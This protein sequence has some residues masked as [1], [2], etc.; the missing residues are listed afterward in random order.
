MTLDS[1]AYRAMR[2]DLRDVWSAQDARCWICGQA[3]DYLAPAHDPEALDLDHIKPRST[4]PH[5]AMDRNNCA[6]A[7]VRCNR[8][9]GNRAVR[10]GIG[11]VTE[12]W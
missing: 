2:A 9:R 1:P 12:A 7:H 6:P 8:S 3:I 4:H 5:L 10:P 11:Q